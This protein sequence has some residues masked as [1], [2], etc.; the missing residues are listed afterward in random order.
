MV[1]IACKDLSKTYAGGKKALKRVSFSFNRN[2]I[3]AIIGRNGAGKTTMVR[4]LSTQ[5][6]STSG[7]AYINGIDVATDPSSVREQIAIVPQEARAIQWLT[8]MQSVV[9]YL[10]YRGFGYRES[11]RR[12]KEM[13]SR[14]EL[15]DTSNKL[16]RLLSGGTKRKVMVATVLASEAKVIFLDEPTTGLDPIS[17]SDLWKMLTKLKDDY[18]IF[19]TTHYLE[20]A[21][22]LADVIGIMDNGRLLTIG[23]M[24]Q[25]RRIVGHQYSLKVF[26]SG[27][28][29]K[30][31]KGTVIK[32]MDGSTQ[33][34]T[35]EAEAFR[36]SKQLISRRMKFSINPVSLEDI[37][38]YI[39][40]RPIENNEGENDEW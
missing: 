24:D 35:G 21:E 25:L 23:S 15:S 29:P 22:C 31:R 27:A 1:G 26:G 40:K 7:H 8:P 6:T 38:Y 4:I 32:G 12:A 18:L 5:L 9:S 37:F 39:V 2:G 16:N 14:M 36:L 19:L 33:V 28:V 13:L 30:P 11:N 10:M 34:L 17:R 3:I 20:E